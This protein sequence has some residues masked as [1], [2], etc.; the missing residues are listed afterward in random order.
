MKSRTKGRRLPIHNELFIEVVEPRVMLS[1]D[2]LGLDAGVLERDLRHDADWDLTDAVSWWGS[3]SS[4]TLDRDE[5][6][7]I[8]APADSGDLLSTSLQLFDSNSESSVGHIPESLNSYLSDDNQ[9]T[10]YREVIFFDTGV[11]DGEQLLSELLRDTDR[12]ATQVYLID[13]TSDG[14]GQITSVLNTHQNLDAVH[15]ISHGSAGQIQLGSGTLST[16]SVE[17]Y[18]EQLQDWGSSLADSGD[19]LI[20][21][22]NLAVD[23]EGRS[24]VDV[25]SGLT[26]ADVAASVDQTGNAEQGGDWELEYRKGSVETAAYTSSG[27]EGWTGMLAINVTTI[28]PLTENT[29]E[30]TDLVFSVA[31]GNAVTVDDDTTGDPVLRTTLTVTNGVLTLASTVGLTTV[32]GDGTDTVVVIGLESAINSALDGLTYS[33]STGYDGAATLQVTADLQANLLG[34]YQF[35]QANPLGQDSSP[36]GGNDGTPSGPGAAPDPSAIFNAT[37]NSDVLVLDGVDDN[38]QIVGR[39][40]TPTDVTLAAWV[41][42]QAVNNQELVSLGGSIAIRLNDTGNGTGVTGF[43]HD[44]FNWN[45]TNSMQFIGG[46]GWHHVAFTFDD[47]SN[48]QVIYIDGVALGT[49]SHSGS[50]N[51]AHQLNSSIGSHANNSSFPLNGMLDEARIYDR[52]LSD[53]E[54]QALA[55]DQY[56]ETEVVSITVSAANSEEVLATNNTLVLNEG[57]SATIDEL[58]LE[59][60][61][62]VQSPVQLVFFFNKVRVYV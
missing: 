17:S 61:D 39:F 62:V 51:W 60:S 38:T 49:T 52:A 27:S 15:I 57:V 35:D 58:L 45:H 18:T 44:G 50:I 9:Q 13:S 24:L 56:S 5:E 3:E 53:G 8:T 33:P 48:S 34:Y 43:Y 14:V 12:S 37:R 47:A 16:H 54:I 11:V 10:R 19:I 29:V 55:S 30:D 23:A 7:R 2:V 25:I 26:A 40:G 46:D 6:S 41:N 36:G 59:T 1:A 28:A 21:G 31:G 42:V 20:Y 4:D 32:T 22:C